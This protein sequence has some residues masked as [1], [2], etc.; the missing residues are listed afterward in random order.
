MHMID[1]KQTSPSSSL[2]PVPG[3]IKTILAA[4]GTAG[5]VLLIGFGLV[6]AAHWMSHLEYDLE[7]PVWRHWIRELSAD[8]IAWKGQ[9]TQTYQALARRSLATMVECAPLTAVEADRPRI[10][11]PDVVPLVEMKKGRG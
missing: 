11:I 1:V 6:R 3:T 4:P 2:S 5:I 9:G 10:D 8:E 7:S